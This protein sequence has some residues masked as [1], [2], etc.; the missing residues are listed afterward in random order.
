MTSADLFR[1]DLA[2]ERVLDGLL[3]LV[4]GVFQLG[5]RD[6]ALFAGAE[7]AVE[8]LVAVK[9]LAAAVTLDDDDG[10][11]LDG[12]I[13]GE[14]LLTLQ[15]FAA[16]ADAQTIVRVA[17]ID[18]FAFLIAAIRALHGEN[19]SHLLRTGACV[20]ASCT[21]AHFLL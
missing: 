19:S 9:L 7:H 13:G 12:L 15:A 18:D 6:W 14:P 1:G 20:R 5:Q 10:Q 8:D 2:V 4:C 11:T 17:G 21:S 16:A 3:D